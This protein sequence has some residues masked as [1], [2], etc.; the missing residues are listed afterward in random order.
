M[1]LQLYKI[2][3]TATTTTNIEP[4]VERFF[5]ITVSDTASNATLTIDADNFVDD[6]GVVGV[7]LPE[8]TAGNSYYRVYINGVL[9]QNGNSVYTPG[10]SGVGKLE[11]NNPATGGTIYT[12]TVVVLEVTTFAPDSTTTVQT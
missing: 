12:G 1:A 5:Y 3:A 9:Q 11:F 7:T 10:G 4:T 2:L 6:T 8:L